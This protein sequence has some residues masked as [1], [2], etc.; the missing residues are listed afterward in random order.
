MVRARDRDLTD[1][2]QLA[3]R[4]KRLQPRFQL[5]TVDAG[6]KVIVSPSCPGS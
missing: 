6:L 5:K 3:P 2:E 4:I 1:L